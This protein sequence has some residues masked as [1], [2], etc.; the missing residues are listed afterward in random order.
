MV[1]VIVW[2]IGD[3]IYVLYQRVVEPPFLFGWWLPRR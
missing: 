1:L 3:V 2:G